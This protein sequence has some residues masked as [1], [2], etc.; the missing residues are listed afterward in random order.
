MP[1]AHAADARSRGTDQI[2]GARSLR[3]AHRSAGAL[4]TPARINRDGHAGERFPAFDAGLEDLVSRDAGFAIAHVLHAGVT[5]H[6]S[7]GQGEQRTVRGAWAPEHQ[8]L[9]S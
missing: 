2:S 1:P 5:G 6:D 9:I 4:A 3:V 8:A 7:D